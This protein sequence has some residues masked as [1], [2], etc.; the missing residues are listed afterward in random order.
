MPAGRTGVATGREQTANAVSTDPAT[1]QDQPR[2]SGDCCTRAINPACGTD[3]RVVIGDP[4]GRT[5]R[6]H[7]AEWMGRG[8]KERTDGGSVVHG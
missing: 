7:H 8:K 6:W 4:N 3:G 1:A 2:R 5:Q